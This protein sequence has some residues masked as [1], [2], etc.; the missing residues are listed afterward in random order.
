MASVLL[1]G[2]TGAMGVYLR[3][4]LA[5]RGDRVFVTSRTKREDED[6]VRFLLGDA[7]DEAF[8]KSAVKLARPDAI[9]DFMIYG[10]DEFRQRRDAL[11]SSSG[12]YVFLS[13]Y[14]V[15]AEQ[16]PL[17]ERSPRL[18]DVCHDTAY[19]STD[20]YALRKAREEDLLRAG[21]S[22][23][24]TIVRPGITYSKNR[25]QFGCLESEL[26]CFRALS[27]VPVVIPS[28][29]LPKRTT[30]TWGR[31]VAR[32][33]AG[34]IGNPKALGDDFNCATG[35][36]RTWNEIATIYGRSIGM[37][38]VT[39]PLDWYIDLLDARYQV[40][41]DRMFDRVIDNTKILAATGIDASSLAPP[42][43]GLAE[44]LARFKEHPVFK[45]I[46]PGQNAVIDRLAKS[47]I[48]LSALSP[49]LR[50]RYL[51][52][53]NPELFQSLPIRLLRGGIRTFFRM[54]RHHQ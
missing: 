52:A 49:S 38:L 1:L 3:N 45:S 27:G 10:T 6:G 17:T 44:E 8:L 15:F 24:W 30:L 35:E 32:M 42:E 21:H 11:V 48:P 34:L 41:F 20:E 23:N 2:G 53:R 14:R 43:I 40:L 47:R 9:V 37:Q 13:S 33:I 28:E 39:C 25:F 36:S 18:L 4:C 51:K 54:S 5:A 26:V 31:D 16:V 22:L 19:L 50:W 46:S 7:H 12:Q 29:M